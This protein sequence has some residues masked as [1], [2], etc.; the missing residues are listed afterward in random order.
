M[1]NLS[2]SLVLNAVERAFLDVPQYLWSWLTGNKYLALMLFLAGLAAGFHKIQTGKSKNQIW[3]G[4]SLILGATILLWA[5]FIPYFTVMGIRPV[6]RVLIL[7]MYI[8][9]WAFVLMGVFTGQQ[10][11]LHLP[12]MVYK[13]SQVSV[14]ALLTFLL[15]WMPV[16]TAILYASNIPDLRLYAQLWDLRD[17]K[18]RQSSLNG[19][20]DVIV[21]SLKH[22]PALHNIQPSF[23][24]EA[25][26]QD[27]TN[28]WINEA[29]AKYYGLK[30]I[31]LRR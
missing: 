23:W 10:L 12:P 3:L 22:D 28:S 30:S 15:F 7:P 20:K 24:I 19:D 13:I 25:D 9:I 21:D 31:R 18:L 2:V 4:L 1:G 11:V 5:G 8:F 6:D 27:D 14:M 29:A 26:L 17:A 16:R